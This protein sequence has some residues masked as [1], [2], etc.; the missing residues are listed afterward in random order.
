[1]NM[2]K[3]KYT[4]LHLPSTIG[5]FLLIAVV[6]ICATVFAVVTLMAASWPVWVALACVVFIFRACGGG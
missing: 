4:L 3:V 2:S 6:A 1:M 5:E